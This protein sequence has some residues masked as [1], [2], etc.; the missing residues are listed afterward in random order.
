MTTNKIPQKIVNPFDTDD[1]EK[2][3]KDLLKNSR[4]ISKAA[5]LQK[6]K[7]ASELQKK[8]NRSSTTSLD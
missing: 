5:A 8:S 4:P 7:E 1:K 2:V 3:W 6:M